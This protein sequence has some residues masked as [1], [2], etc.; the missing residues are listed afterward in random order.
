VK[1]AFLGTSQFA[2][3]ALA[4]IAERHDVTLVVTQPDRPVGRHAVLTPPPVKTEAERLGLAVFQPERINRDA[5]IERLRDAAADVFVVAA[6]GQLLKPAVFD[7]PPLGTINIHA[8]LLPAYRGGAPVHWAIIRGE[9]ETGI[10]TFYIEAGMDTGDVL[11]KRPIGI[12]PDETAGELEIRLA[13]L[14]GEVI[15]ETLSRVES[16]DLKAV[17]QP[18]DG[19]SM[20]PL[21]SRETGRIDW[22]APAQQI[23]NLVRGTNPW[24][25]AW[26]QL[27]GERVKVHRTARTDVKC[28]P[29]PPGEVALRD[30]D[31]LLVGTGD[32]LIEIL[33]AQRE[34]KPRVDGAAFLH[35]LHGPARLT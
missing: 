22:T 1:V 33:E 19:V 9:T 15:L 24:P 18:V 8:S 7:M 28:G 20:A 29:I 31:R 27:D 5:A 30:T 3:P 2:C 14:G 23:H 25:G 35:G 34:G 21:M 13:V 10:S 17:P 32:Y 4:A 12:G 26:T 6:Y 11:L 16:G